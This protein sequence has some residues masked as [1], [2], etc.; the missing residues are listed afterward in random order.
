MSKCITRKGVIL[1]CQECKITKSDYKTQTL[2]VSLLEA[3]GFGINNLDI[4][5]YL[6]S[7]VSHIAS[8]IFEHITPLYLHACINGHK[9]V[10]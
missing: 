5:Q 7:R 6:N 2:R 9:T 4:F 3:R 1:S 10:Y 8:Y